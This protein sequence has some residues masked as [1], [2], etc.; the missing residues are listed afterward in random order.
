MSQTQLQ[1]CRAVVPSDTDPTQPAPFGAGSSEPQVT[2][3]PTAPATGHKATGIMFLVAADA[4]TSCAVWVRDPATGI[5][6][7]LATFGATDTP[8][9]A[10]FQWVTVCNLNAS[11]LYFVTDASMSSIDP[12]TEPLVLMVETSA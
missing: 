10:T 12:L 2:M 4:G 5:W 7:V 6:G 1:R 3:S 9:F 11:E 8:A